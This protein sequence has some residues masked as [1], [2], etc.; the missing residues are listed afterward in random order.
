MDHTLTSIYLNSPVVKSITIKKI[1]LSVSFANYIVVNRGDFR[2]LRD[3]RTDVTVKDFSTRRVIVYVCILVAS[4][5]KLSYFLLY[6][7]S[8]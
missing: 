6:S 1:T 7:G 4:S 8:T 5:Q 3:G 2:D